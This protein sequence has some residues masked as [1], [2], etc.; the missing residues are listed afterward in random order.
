MS[1]VECD[2]RYRELALGRRSVSRRYDM[3]RFGL[4]GNGGSPSR[5]SLGGSACVKGENLH[6]HAGQYRLGQR[7]H[8]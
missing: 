1:G 8:D 5:R 4:I 6:D 3:D 2:F 7:K